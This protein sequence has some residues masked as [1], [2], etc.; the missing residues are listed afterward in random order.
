[1]NTLNLVEEDIKST[2]R[3]VSAVLHFG[4]ME[5]NKERGSDQATMPDNTVA[6]KVCQLLK[7]D[8]NS[9]TRAL[10]RPKIKVIFTL[11]LMV[12][13]IWL[14]YVPWNVQVGCEYVTKAQTKDEVDFV[15]EALSKALY[16]KLFQWG[17]LRVNR[18]LDKTTRKGSSFIGI[19]D[20]AGCE[21]FE[22]WSNFD[23]Q[24]FSIKFDSFF[25]YFSNISTHFT[26]FF[27]KSYKWKITLFIDE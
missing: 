26:Q 12:I 10:L 5:F 8:I 16:E 1:M 11:F 15:V 19:L 20:I 2:L 27:R 3:V 6:Q 9:F 18:S 13:Y 7:L 23:Q 22:V 17:V 25:R 14:V 24:I 21:I 4:N